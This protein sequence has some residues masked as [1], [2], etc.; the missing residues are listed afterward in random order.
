[1][2]ITFR[3]IFLFILFCMLYLPVFAQ[4]ANLDNKLRLAQSYE[5]AGMFDK[6]KSVYEDLYKQQPSNFMFFEGLNRC[7]INLK[8]YDN[9]IIILQKMVSEFPNE[10]NFAGLLG[11][12]YYLKNEQNKAFEIW[13]KALNIPG[14][15]VINYRIIT[16]YAL[17]NRAFDKAIE[18]LK[19]GKEINADKIGFSLEL[20]NLLSITMKYNEAAEEYC[21]VLLLQPG[22]IGMVKSRFISYLNQH[23][24]LDQTLTV[25]EQYFNDYKNNPTFVELLTFLYLQKD[26]YNSAYITV[27]KWDDLTNSSGSKI[28][29]FAQD[30]LTDMQFEYASLA[31][32]YIID[33]YS[34]T[35]FIPVAKIGYARSLHSALNQKYNSLYPGWKT[36]S[37][38]DTNGSYEYKEII[39]AYYELT[40]EYEKN[41]DINSEAL[42]YI[43]DVYRNK[44]NINDSASVIFNKI[45]SAAPFSVFAG[46]AYFQLAYIAI[47]VGNLKDAN[48]YL[49]RIL[50]YNRV[51]PGELKEAEYYKAKITFWQGDFEKTTKI[52]GNITKEL[53]ENITNDALSLLVIINSLK[54]DS[55]TL[56]KFAQADMFAEQKKFSMAAEIYL[57]LSE[58]HDLF[59]LKNL[60]LYYY[61]EMMI[62]LNL[63]PN[64]VIF[65]ENLSNT[66]NMNI[67]GDKSLF[68][69]GNLYNYGFN[70]KNNAKICFQKLLEKFP[71]SL[72]IDQA[73]DFL[74]IN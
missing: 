51:T 7:Y 50:Q 32:K 73:R 52:L 69:L 35:P 10:V 4:S 8:E 53:A 72:Y 14:A 6:A 37:L 70:D 62:A 49:D 64:A 12:T 31:F 27:I 34:G 60:A 1:M 48:E 55:L 29:S 36:Y 46:K 28:F 56:S 40:K 74:N 9:S 30:A 16:N 18:I 42:Y 44:F 3:Y 59:F 68:L 71:N 25:V 54:S 13:D 23:E 20:A 43:G 5:Q 15:N 61:S 63:Y 67:F 47:E 66:E 17:Q 19:K 45:V 38:P 24:A 11:N 41:Q 57:S 22:Q 2:K 33:K 65:L 21:S 58:N 39:S 26:D